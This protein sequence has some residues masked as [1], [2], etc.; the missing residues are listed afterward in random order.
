MP[1]EFPYGPQFQ[2]K[3]LALYVREPKIALS[4]V[5]PSYFQ[6]PIHIEIASLVKK[7]YAKHDVSEAQL[8]KAT[9]YTVV[10]GWL[11]SK[12]REIWPEYKRTIKRLFADD[13]SDKAVVVEQALIFARERK[14]RQALVA[15]EQDVNNSNYEAVFKRFDGLKGFGIEKDL[16]IEY[17]ANPNDPQRWKSGRDGQIGTFFLPTLDKMMEGGAGSG[18]LALILAGGK[19]GKSSLLAR[20]AAGALWQKKNAAIAT[21]ELS[22]EK[23]R[24]RI[25]AMI[26]GYSTSDLTRIAHLM[27]AE[28][29]RLGKEQLQMME[30]ALYNM[31]AMHSQMKGRLFIKQW[32]TGKGKI[33]DID[34]WI[35]DL[36]QTKGEAIHW[37]GVDYVRVFKPNT[38]HDD[39]RV[40][41]GEVSL[42]LREIATYR[43]IPVWSA[44]QTNRSALNKDRLGPED[45]AEDISQFWTLDFLIAF[46]QT[47]QEKQ[48]GE[49]D[50][51][52]LKPGEKPPP[53]KGRLYLISARDVGGGGVVPVNI[54][55]N[56]FEVREQ[57]K[58]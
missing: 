7:L 5:E 13:L 45:I 28:K 34:N 9:L 35:D 25:D 12:R 36:E 19:A 50:Y 46:S 41:I 54:W 42:N 16:G 29:S 24:K 6:S 18:E 58:L 37:L 27:D 11:G 4:V 51:K 20:F 22:A 33:R 53:E 26:T 38:S 49:Y 47:K 15:A 10:K 17:W 32:P 39:H 31:R 23:Y 56:T 1:A 3:I 44:L 14:F 52:K 21:G 55:R 57:K 8:S 48:A 40:S 2:E 43:K 30:K